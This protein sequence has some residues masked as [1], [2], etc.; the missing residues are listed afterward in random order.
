M[1]RFYTLKSAA[2]A[3]QLKS[4][5]QG[6][7]SSDSQEIIKQKGLVSLLP[8]PT[9]PLHLTTFTAWQCRQC[10]IVWP[11]FAMPGCMLWPLVGE[12]GII[13]QLTGISCM[14]K[15]APAALNIPTVY[16]ILIHMTPDMDDCAMHQSWC[17]VDASHAQKGDISSRERRKRKHK[18]V[19]VFPLPEVSLFCSL[20]HNCPSGAFSVSHAVW[21]YLLGIVHVV[22]QVEHVILL[23][24]AGG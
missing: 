9:P 3:L 15:Q 14:C 8:F 21:R 23:M 20:L 5:A 16:D 4:E 17:G 12:R 7:V 1:R 10:A 24:S 19:R 6:A 22:P 11:S 13:C 18:E 2:K